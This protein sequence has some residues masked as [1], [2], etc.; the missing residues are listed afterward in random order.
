MDDPITQIIKHNP[1][2]PQGCDVFMTI[3]QRGHNYLAKVEDAVNDW[4]IGSDPKPSMA[5]AVEDVLKDTKLKVNKLIVDFCEGCLRSGDDDEAF[6]DDD[7]EPSDMTNV[8]ADADTLKSAG[9]GTN[10]DYGGYDSG[11]YD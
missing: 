2:K 6:C 11:Y 10:E 3:Y 1:G 5:E 8:E 7:D 9:Y 4:E